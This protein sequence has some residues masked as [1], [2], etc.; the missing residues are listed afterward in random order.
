MLYCFITV[1]LP[2]GFKK[3][4]GGIF[5]QIALIILKIKILVILYS[6]LILIN[7]AIIVSIENQRTW[8]LN[9]VEHQDVI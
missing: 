4:A 8:N 7:L 2:E 6:M 9:F 3:C 1:N 5:W